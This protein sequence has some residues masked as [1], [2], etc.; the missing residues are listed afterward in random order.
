MED[1]LSQ[2]RATCRVDELAH[3]NLIVFL[4]KADLLKRKLESGVRIRQWIKSYGMRA[5][6]VPAAKE[7]KKAALPHPPL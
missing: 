3:I 4:N 2:W 5:N 6:T 1:A 7:C